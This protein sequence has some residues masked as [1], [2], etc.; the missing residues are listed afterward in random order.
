MRT[1]P[2]REVKVQNDL[3]RYD[4]FGWDYQHFG[5]LTDDEIKWYRDFACKTGGPVLELAV[6]TGRLLAKLAEAGCRITGIDLSDKMIE[7][8]RENIRG[9]PD[10]AKS[11]IELSKQDI[12]RFSFD[13]L[14]RL[15]YIADNSFRELS[16]KEAQLG[17]LRA[18]H[19]HMAPDGLFLLTVRRFD[20]S[21]FANG[22]LI[23]PWSEQRIDPATGNKVSRQV[24][25]T[26]SDDNRVLDGIYHY[27]VVNPRGNES[28]E[29]CSFYAPILHTEDYRALFKKCRLS[30]DVYI[31]YS[32]QKDDGTGSPLCFVCRKE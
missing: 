5:P 1:L 30:A 24:E 13:Q 11:N 18:V 15:I 14:F 25:F 21:R 6:G 9:L 17:C 4:L 8:A 10:E 20:T 26:L 27:K 29:Q 19:D 2:I 12:T 3:K 22:K 7:I 28:M 23:V 32:M 16:T 31:D